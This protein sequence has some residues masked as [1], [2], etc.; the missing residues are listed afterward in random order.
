MDAQEEPA[1]GGPLG[2][3]GGAELEFPVSFDLR[4]IYVLAEGA[5]IAEDLEAIY[6]ELG[7]RCTMIQG[8]AKPGAKYGRMGS[9]LSFETREQMY[10]T[11]AAIGKLP[12]VKTAI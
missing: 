12:Y 8:I 11:Y 7:V 6:R 5:T 1:T 10:A 2:V 3:F 9:R 4:I